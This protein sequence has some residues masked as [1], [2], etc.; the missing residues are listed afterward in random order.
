MNFYRIKSVKR[1]LAA[2]VKCRPMPDL[3]FVMIVFPIENSIVDLAQL[4]DLSRDRADKVVAR[5]RET[6]ANVM[7]AEN[8][9]VPAVQ[10]N[11]MPEQKNTRDQVRN[12]R[13]PLRVGRKAA[14]EV[15]AGAVAEEGLR[16]LLVPRRRTQ[17][18]LSANTA[19]L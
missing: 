11:L 12:I 13:N 5:I 1:V 6:T 18:Q 14:A 9:M 15:A 4:Q 19:K 3:I 17:Q 10:K 7:V 2:V 16:N 8:M